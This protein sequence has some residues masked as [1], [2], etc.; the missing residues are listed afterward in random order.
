MKTDLFQSCGHCWVFQICW[1]TECSTFTASSFKIWGKRSASRYQNE[2]P[3]GEGSAAWGPWGRRWGGV[4]GRSINS[5]PDLWDTW[6]S[7][8]I[9]LTI[10]TSLLQTYAQPKKLKIHISLVE[11]KFYRN[12]DSACNFTDEV[13]QGTK[14]ILETSRTSRQE[15]KTSP[16]SQNEAQASHINSAMLRAGDVSKSK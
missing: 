6:C 9:V 4:G 2:R 1:H 16:A 8:I 15:L 13:R 12:K 10:S 3:L 14:A 5:I 7:R 11:K